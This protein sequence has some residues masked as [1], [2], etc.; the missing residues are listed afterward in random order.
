[1]AHF[2]SCRI[3]LTSEKPKFSRRLRATAD[4]RG[5]REARVYGGLKLVVTVVARC[6]FL[7]KTVIPDYGMKRRMRCPI[8]ALPCG[9][10]PGPVDR[11]Q[12]I[13]ADCSICVL[14]GG[15][16]QTLQLLRS[17]CE[18]YVI[19]EISHF[20][21]SREFHSEVKCETFGPFHSEITNPAPA[22]H[23]SGMYGEIAVPLKGARG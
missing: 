6:S 5:P 3:A 19:C 23:S 12:R 14:C 20:F 15:T 13:R 9:S 22:L 18:L 7:C 8:M 10:S 2:T 11:A 1:M 17:I 4:A 16:T 21:I